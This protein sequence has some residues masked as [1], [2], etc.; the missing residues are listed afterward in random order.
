MKHKL[1]SWM[2]VGAIHLEKLRLCK[3]NV[4]FLENIIEKH[5]FFFVLV[6]FFNHLF[7]AICEKHIHIRQYVE[8]L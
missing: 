7:I 1:Y 2:N 3:L 4:H 8:I 6:V 5:L